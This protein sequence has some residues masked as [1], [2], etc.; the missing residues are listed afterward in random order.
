MSYSHIDDKKEDGMSGDG[1]VTR[2]RKRLA[3]EIEKTLGEEF[4]IFQDIKDINWGDRW[5]I[6]TRE[7]VKDV[8]F[9]IP[10]ITNGFFNSKESIEELDIFL[11]Y[12]T[13]LKRQDLILPV[14]FAETDIIE[15]IK[16][17]I[18]ERNE[19]VKGLNLQIKEIVEIIK[20][21]DV[22]KKRFGGLCD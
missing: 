20:S 21:N 15:A 10:I 4:L 9:I 3:L 11:D 12:E 8:V 1:E 22:S 16:E 6:T 18:K 13:R 19:E 2:F 17:R 14:Y 5:R 7:A